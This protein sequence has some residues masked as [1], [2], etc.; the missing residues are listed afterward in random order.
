MN[1]PDP[2]TSP[3]SL[4]G[5]ADQIVAAGVQRIDGAVVGDASRY[6]DE[7]FVPS[8]DND[9]RGIEA[10]PNDALLVNDARVTGDPLRATDPAA[11]RGP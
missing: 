4:D 2:V 7:L 1:D 6:D 5:L 3:T 11:R 8:W 9:V 10:G